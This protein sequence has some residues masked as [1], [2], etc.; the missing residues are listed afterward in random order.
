VKNIS[1]SMF[2]ALSVLLLGCTT[3]N[4]Y[5]SPPVSTAQT[6]TA[7]VA[8][9]AGSSVVSDVAPAVASDT[10]TVP[11][12][13]PD[14]GTSMD[15][16]AVADTSKATDVS[17]GGLISDTSSV[18]AE[19]QEPDTL[20]INPKD[21]QATDTISADAMNTTTSDAQASEAGTGSDSQA[22]S[23]PCKLAWSGK[24]ADG[25]FGQAIPTNQSVGIM[26]FGN[27]DGNI[28][29]F[30][31]YDWSGN[32][33]SDQIALL[34]VRS[35]I[36]GND[37]YMVSVL[38]DRG[39]G[40]EWSVYPLSSD[41]VLGAKQTVSFD[42]DKSELSVPFLSFDGTYFR[43]TT[44]FNGSDTWCAGGTVF[45]TGRI[46]ANGLYVSERQFCLSAARKTVTIK[47]VIDDGSGNPIFVVGVYNADQQNSEQTMRVVDAAGVYTVFASN[48]SQRRAI[49]VFPSATGPL[50]SWYMAVKT[51][52]YY[53]SPLDDGNIVTA[54]QMPAGFIP[55]L[56]DGSSAV[57]FITDY[58]AGTKDMVTVS[59]KGQELSRVQLPP[60]KS[61]CSD[62]LAG[63]NGKYVNLDA[64][65]FG[66][67]PE[68]W[69]T[70][71][72]CN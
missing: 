40:R 24:I 45:F 17:D 21:A 62:N 68:V 26:W 37:S 69:A 58:L 56:V 41:G 12:I 19:A 46:A 48:D 23:P 33:T 59:L 20:P 70:I 18:D 10:G 54:N 2:V 42:P 14:S 28:L 60:A 72:T 9:D 39:T 4:N 67:K 53:L 65:C 51:N 32:P 50:L 43:V 61:N 38:D 27:G 29:Y 49:D 6:P 3:N 8:T 1:V 31:S 13:V 7:T 11:M 25:T 52:V 22:A 71:V 64:G 30:R 55:E 47:R 44:L 15:V 5:F 66:E 16:K 57:G 36:G 35:I 63:N 34:N